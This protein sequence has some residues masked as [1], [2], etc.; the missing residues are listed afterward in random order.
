M[1]SPKLDDEFFVVLM[2]D[3]KV[4]GATTRKFHKS[5]HIKSMPGLRLL[6]LNN[7]YRR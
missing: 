6:I 5:E 3:D 7:D 1:K 2:G 4:K